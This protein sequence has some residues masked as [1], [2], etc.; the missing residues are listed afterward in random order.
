MIPLGELYIRLGR[1]EDA[2]IIYLQALHRDSVRTSGFELGLLPGYSSKRKEYLKGLAQ[3]LEGIQ[4]WK[5]AKRTYLEYG[6]EFRSPQDL[7]FVYSALARIAEQ[8][9]R[10]D[11]SKDYLK[12]LNEVIPSDN[13]AFQIGS[14]HMRL[15]EYD[16]AVDSFDDVIRLSD[17]DEM[18]VDASAQMIIAMLK[19]RKIPQADVRINVF[20]QSFESLPSFNDYIAEFALE[21]GKAYIADKNFD[22]ALESL[23]EATRRYRRT[24]FRPE[25]ELEIGRV[26]LITNKT[27]EALDILTEM[28]DRYADHPILAKVYLNLGDHYFQNQQYDN[29]VR[30]LL[31][32][33]D[34]DRM[35]EVIP[36]AMRYLIRVY[37][38]IRMWDAALALTRR[39]IQDYPDAVDVLQ[40]GV[41]IG[42]FYMKLNEYSRAIDYFRDL[43]YEADAETE[44]EIQYWIG[45][46]FYSMGLFEQAVFEYLKVE[47]LS[48][49]TKLPWN[50]TAIY[51]A[52]QAYLKLD[53]PE[54]AKKMFEKI[55]RKEGAT[56]DLGRIAREK[57]AEIDAGLMNDKG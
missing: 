55:V 41:Q 28:P 43:K 32:A 44:A 54:Q 30:A 38:S 50:T 19:Q 49:P 10:I 33:M 14:L 15:A 40:K 18:K 29:A 39:Y 24:A 8:E 17:N 53:E 31:L 3:A 23:E 9:G 45:D 13:T 36:V 35:P 21:K 22:A 47:Y 25:A 51:Q 34:E 52:G 20:R 56:S 11:R 48:K 46:C 6:R 16:Q 42:T 5:D 12:K 26:Y 27:E 7:Q 1:F 2:K 57:I 37:D 4:S